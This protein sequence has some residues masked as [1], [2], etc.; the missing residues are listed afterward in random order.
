MH[1]RTRI[2]VCGITST[3]DAKGAIQIGVDA[4]GFIFAENSPRYISPEKAKEIVTQLPPFIHFV[5]VFVDK[6]PIEIQEIIEYCGLSYVQLHG[7]EDAEYCRKLAQAATPCMLIKAFRVG[8][9][10]MAADFTSY[11]DSV[12]GFL[13]DTYIEGQKGGTGKSFDWSIIESLKLQLPVILAG[14][15]TPE[16]V[17][18]AIRTV[19][20]FAIDLNSG[21]EEEPGKKDLARLR[22]LVKVVD[23]VDAEL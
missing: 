11:E 7:G 2:K 18:E 6:D 3:E 16:N 21:V 8:S 14:G 10:T 5:G 9:R 13:L 12:K 4:I 1:S 19:R 22:S 17:A 15:L 23:G 20:P